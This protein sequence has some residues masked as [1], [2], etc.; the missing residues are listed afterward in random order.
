VV[1]SDILSSDV[2]HTPAA[3]VSWCVEHTALIYLYI[4]TRHFCRRIV[5][6]YQMCCKVLVVCICV[7]IYVCVCVFGKC[8]CMCMSACVVFVCVFVCVCMCVCVSLY[9]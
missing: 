2:M 7:C 1:S 6:C 8:V 9:I 5:G 3:C 4:M